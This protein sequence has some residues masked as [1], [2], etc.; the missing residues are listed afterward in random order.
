M[1]DA[2]VTGSLLEK[3]SEDQVVTEFHSSPLVYWRQIAVI[4]L[5]LWSLAVLI[6]HFMDVPNGIWTANVVVAIV[7][8]YAA[9]EA[10]KYVSS[11]WRISEHCLHINESH[12]IPLSNISKS[13][14]FLGALSVSTIKGQTFAIGYL[15]DP[16]GASNLI[17]R[18][19]NK[20]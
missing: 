19:R 4:L 10:R 18:K 6:F 2:E 9:I 1:S 11:R 8:A 15:R 13:R 5:F 16:V 17:L 12:V 14:A 20:E 3:H 7:A